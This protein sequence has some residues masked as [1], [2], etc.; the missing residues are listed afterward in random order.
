MGFLKRD[1]SLLVSFSQFCFVTEF[2]SH[3]ISLC[4]RRSTQEGVEPKAAQ[5]QAQMQQQMVPV[6]DSYMQNRAEAL[7][8]VES[9]IVELSNIF[10][11]LATMVAQHGEMAIRIDENMDDTLANVEGAQGQLLKYLNSISSNRWLIIKIF[12]VLLAFLLIFVVFVA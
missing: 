5:G 9:T 2:A 3:S 6:Q 11:Q 10:S 1:N 8:N 4:R 7:Q 12:F